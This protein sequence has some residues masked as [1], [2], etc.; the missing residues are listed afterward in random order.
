MLWVVFSDTDWEIN[1]PASKEGNYSKFPAQ[2][3]IRPP[4]NL[5]TAKTP[6]KTQP[7]DELSTEVFHKSKNAP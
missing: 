7:I 4:K 2:A 3:V 1:G 5:S 6:S